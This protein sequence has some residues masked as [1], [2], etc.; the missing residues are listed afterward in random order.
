MIRQHLFSTRT[1]MIVVMCGLIQA[2]NPKNVAPNFI[3]I[4]VDDLGYADLGIYADPK[5]KTPAIDQLVASGQSWTDFYATSSVCSPSRGALLTGN[6][7]VRSGLYGDQISVFWPG[8]KT[9]I[10]P[11]QTTLPEVFQQ[12]QYATGIF[13]KWHLGDA[14]HALPTRHGFDEWVGTPYSNDMDWNVDD[15]TSANIFLDPALTAAKWDKVGP[16]LNH[17]ILH[18]KV[19]D[20]QVPLER[21][22]RAKDGSY[23]DAVIERPADQTKLTQRYTQ[24]SINF[25]Q[26]AADAKKP[27]FLLLSHSMPHVPL[28]RSKSFVNKSATGLYG[29]VME[30]IDWSLGSIMATL[31]EQGIAENTYLVFT[32]DNGPWLRY[33]DHGGSAGPLREGKG[34]TFEGG[35]RVMTIFAGP[36]IQSGTVNALGMQ[37]DIYNTFLSLAAITPSTEAL[38]SYDLSQTLTKGGDSPR[39][40]VPYY[41][42]SELRAFRVGTKKLHFVT[43]APFGAERVVHEPPQ[44]ID[45]D[46]DIGEAQDVALEQPEAVALVQREKMLFLKDLQ[47]KA[48]ILDRQ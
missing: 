32:S 45:L 6:L 17:R 8:S 7:P 27:F 20:W 34:T 24:E 21:S 38:D 46:N 35:V 23:E 39:R 14:D 40:F 25:I 43:S 4:Y 36:N 47:V 16:I 37:T 2:C 26:R 33:N 5:L 13:G 30:E 11:E 42:G 28:F 15:I 44:L 12:H 29:D 19:A 1:L 22:R 3:I 31:R 9:G 10:S 18:P 48:S 41:S